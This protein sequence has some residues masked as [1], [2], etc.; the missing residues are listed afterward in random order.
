MATEIRSEKM[1]YNVVATILGGDP[2]RMRRLKLQCAKRGPLFD[3]WETAYRILTR[4]D[5]SPPNPATEW[6]KLKDVGVRLIFNDEDDYPAMLREIHD[7]PLAIYIRGTLPPLPYLS[8]VGT[9]RATPEGKSMTQKFAREL[10]GAGFAI[11]SGLALGI[12]SAAHEGCLEAHGKT[13]AVL[14][15]GL[16][17]IFPSENE[18]LGNEILAAGGAIISEY[19]LGQPS[20]GSRFLERN[21]II[22][23]LSQGTVVVEAPLHSGSLVTA[24]LALEENR[25]VFVVPGPVSHPNFFGSHQVIRQGA[26]LVTKPEEI[27]EAYD[28]LA[29]VAKAKEAAAASEEEKQVLIA[30][31]S[32]SRPLEVDKIIE[33]TKLEPQV[34][35]QTL[36]FLLIKQ[37]IKETETGYIIE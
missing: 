27:L 6:E 32:V 10:T 20:Y 8:I 22:S 28:M 7:P 2:T 16:H 4:H 36:S 3:N 23:G 5:R 35:S 24:R 17:D 18:R 37:L 11:V 12:D 33:M 13:I 15:G 14:A 21:R 34:A 26:E 29:E 31:R 9:R 19:P 1:F 25:D 30:L